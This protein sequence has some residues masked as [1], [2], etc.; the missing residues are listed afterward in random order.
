VVV[1]VG[2]SDPLVPS[3]QNRDDQNRDVVVVVVVGSS[4]PLVPSYQ[5]HDVQS[6]GVQSH[7]DHDHDVRNRDDDVENILS[8]DPSYRNH[9]GD[10]GDVHEMGNQILLQ[11]RWNLKKKRMKRMS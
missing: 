4:D 2:S 9:D 7:D 8:L 1:V 5:S 10:G 6:H 3:Y 11:N